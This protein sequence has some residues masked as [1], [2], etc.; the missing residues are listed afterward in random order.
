MQHII[1]TG[2]KYSNIS[3]VLNI[4]SVIEDLKIIYEPRDPKQPFTEFEKKQYYNQNVLTKC[5]GNNNQ[6]S[7]YLYNGKSYDILHVAKTNKI[8]YIHRDLRDIVDKVD[9]SLIDE[10]INLIDILDHKNILDI[11]YDNIINNPVNA[12]LEISDFI[13][14]NTEE[15]KIKN[16]ILSLKDP[17]VGSWKDNLEQNKDLINK[18]LFNLSH[19]L[20]HYGYEKDN[21][22]IKKLT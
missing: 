5:P 22:W 6:F 7:K 9:Q 21:S 2:H 8:I 1:L 19:Y 11:S 16:N 3:T 15:L 12:I 20:F 18:Y 13:G 10:V 17:T 14:I 4:L